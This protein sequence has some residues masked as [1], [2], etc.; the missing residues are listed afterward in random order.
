MHGACA[1]YARFDAPK[2]SV[3]WFSLFEKLLIQMLVENRASTARVRFV[4]FVAA[5]PSAFD[6]TI[7]SV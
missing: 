4:P 2:I 5:F 3:I 1:H 7:R 6:D